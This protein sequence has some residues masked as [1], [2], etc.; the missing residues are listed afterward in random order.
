MI[1]IAI[2][3]SLNLQIVRMLSSI[4]LSIELLSFCIAFLSLR[5][6]G[7][8]FSYVSIFYLGFIFFIELSSFSVAKF[9]QQDGT[10][11]YNVSIIFEV[12]YVN[13]GIYLSL[14]P[15]QRF[16]M[17]FA[18]INFSIFGISY[19]CETLATGFQSF[20][21]ITISIMSII[22]VVWSLYYYLVL[23]KQ[24]EVIILKYHAKFWWMAGVLMYYF[25]GTVYN[26]F[27]IVLLKNHESAFEPL[28]Y[29][30]LFLNIILYSTWSYSFLCRSLQKKSS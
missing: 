4:T 9:Y 19:L 15:F 18:I 11:L 16:A 24:Q 7:N 27:L 22:F 20:N 29:V 10:W 3:Y 14:K 2:L 13:Y 5:K 6:E 17:G 23:I 25:G 12:A 21:I 30:M 28:A 8:T 26:L 1:V